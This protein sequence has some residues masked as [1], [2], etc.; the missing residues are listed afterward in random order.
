MGSIFFKSGHDKF[1]ATDVVSNLWNLKIKDLDL[2]ERTLSEYKE[3][4]SA[5]IFVNVACK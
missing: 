4:K 1:K 3:G 5:F 2:T